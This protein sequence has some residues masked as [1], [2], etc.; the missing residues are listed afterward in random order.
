MKTHSLK[1]IYLEYLFASFYCVLI[2]MSIGILKVYRIVNKLLLKKY[3]VNVNFKYLL[4][5]VTAFI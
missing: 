1:I 4:L 5:K 2:N 3:Y